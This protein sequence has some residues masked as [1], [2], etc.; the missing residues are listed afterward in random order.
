M[1]AFLIITKYQFSNILKSKW[2][3]FIM[4]FSIGLNIIFSNIFNDFQKFIISTNSI[5]LI[6]IPLISVLFSGIYYYDNLKFYELLIGN[7]TNRK[8]IIS[9]VI[10]TVIISISISFLL[11]ALII[12][13]IYFGFSNYLIK[14]TFLHFLLILYFSLI[15]FF[16][17]ILNNDK[18]KGI[19]ISIIIYLIFSIFYDALILFI[20]LFFSDYPIENLILYISSLNPI[21]T[22]RTYFLKSLGFMENIGQ[23]YHLISNFFLISTILQIFICLIIFILIVSYFEKKEF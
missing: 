21:L 22:I 4:L 15:S 20:L 10:F 8:V 5:Y 18:L 11:P 16:I 1:R 17:A 9:S 13:I 3:I 19:S 14:F 2:I 7:F 23:I 12:S 6:I